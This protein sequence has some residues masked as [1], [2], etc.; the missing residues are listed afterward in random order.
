[1]T[2]LPSWDRKAYLKYY[3]LS[4]LVLLFLWEALAL[5]VKNPALPPPLLALQQFVKIFPKTL[6]QHVLISTY[7]VLISLGL[8]LIF[9]V[10]LGLLLSRKEKLDRFLAPFIYLLYPV[11]KIALLPVIIAIFNIG[12]VSKIFTITLVIFFQILVTTRD[13]ARRVPQYSIYSVLSLGASM[14]D[15]YRHVIIPAC[16][17]DIF[18]AVRISLGT[19]IAVLFFAESFATLR[20]LGYFIMEAWSRFHYPDVFA[21]ILGI[22]ILGFCLFLL[23]DLVQRLVCPWLFI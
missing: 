4:F 17:P 23:V 16:L 2:M 22:S 19:A 9:A 13:A 12:E 3:L 10:P 15:I 11:P 21:G 14:K 18:T 1:V 7:R 20:G 6:W 8:G 5:L